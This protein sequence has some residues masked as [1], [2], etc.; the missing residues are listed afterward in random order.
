M[1]YPITPV[2]RIANTQEEFNLPI[3]KTEFE[4]NFLQVRRQTSRV[5]R[6]FTLD[7]SNIKLAEFNFLCD[8]WKANVGIQVTFIHPQTGEN[9]Q[10]VIVTSTLAK[11]W[12]TPSILSCKIE[13]EEI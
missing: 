6:K 10:A 12:V 13:I 8:F 1:I 3:I 5:R 9:I 7:Y 4:A 2:P 11:R